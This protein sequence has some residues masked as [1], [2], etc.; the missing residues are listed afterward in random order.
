MSTDHHRPL[1]GETP[2]DPEDLLPEDSVLGLVEYVEMHAAVGHRTRY[3]ILYRLIHSGDMSPITRTRP[4]RR[5]Q[6]VTTT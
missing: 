1:Q 6:Y 3:E 4:R 2:E 5:R